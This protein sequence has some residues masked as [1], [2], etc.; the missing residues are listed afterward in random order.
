MIAHAL[1]LRTTPLLCNG[2]RMLFDVP[3]R[4]VEEWRKHVDDDEKWR[5]RELWS[6]FLEM[7]AAR[8]LEIGAEAAALKRH[9]YGRGWSAKNLMN[10]Y[11]A[12][13][14]GGHKVG[15]YKKT[16]PQ[17]APG[18]WR[19]LLRNYTSA[20]KQMLP[21]E[22]VRWLAEQWTEFKG[23][24]DCVEATHRHVIDLWLQGKPIPGYGTV[25][26]WCRRAGR[27]R[28]HP[29]LYRPGE[30][31]GGW[32]EATF[33][34]NLPKRAVVRE[35]IAHGYLAAHHA[36]PDQVL[37]DRSPLLPL[38]YVFLD[39]TRPDLRCLW[40]NP[41]GKGDFVYPLMVLA[42]D[43]C[44]GVDVGTTFKPRGIKH[45]AAEDAGARQERHGVTQDMTLYAIV[46]V[47]RFGVPP[48]G[49]T[50]VHENAAA[51]VPTWAK[52]FLY[53]IYGDRIKFMA[54]G[55]FKEKMTAHGFAD[56]GGAPYDKAPIEAFF[57]IVMTQTARL[58]GSTGP[59]WETIPGEQKQV[60][61]YELKLLEKAGGVESVFKMFDHKSLDW[62]QAVDG[63]TAALHLL[64]FRTGHKLQGFDRVR[65]WRHDASHS[66]R[67][68]NEFLALSQAEQ[69]AVQ[70]IINRVEAPAERFCRL[71]QGVPLLPV[72]ED[73][74]LY[75]QGPRQ[76]VRVRDGKIIVRSQ[77]HSDDELV[78]RETDNALLDEE[79]ERRE[80][81]AVIAEDGSRIV[82]VE[83]GRV[84]G[85]VI[86]Q[87]RVV[88]GTEAWD[89]E[90]GRV[91][92]ARVADRELLRGY[93]LLDTDT[94]LAEM[95][96][97]NEAIAANLPA[98]LPTAKPLQIE[99]KQRRKKQDKRA[100]IE[101][102]I[103]AAE[104]LESEK[105]SKS[106]G[107]LYDTSSDA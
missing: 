30:L 80:F 56:Q 3:D 9:H 22:F 29:K 86:R 92:A 70:D 21:P 81:D 17:Y 27:A 85:H 20:K 69:D 60:E 40:F 6:S 48:W 36:Q 47:L 14:D 72:D 8:N 15:D 103:A 45:A 97:R 63:I 52:E 76:K 12:Y 61:K 13:R 95:R 67:P 91:R 33:R 31:P 5:L 106:E 23:R 82:L 41:Q 59:R 37:T 68:W 57:R 94:A 107:S 10:L 24:K 32:S 26:E 2:E 4:D 93:L 101:S 104:R 74:L 87:G 88:R 35:Q 90:A 64:R 19:I 55:I 83:D 38:Q 77:A 100:E 96:A 89:R 71:L 39:D 66:Y 78:F 54:T 11:R 1:T 58:P 50:F 16:G 73:M 46:Q 79:N 43:A 28:P 53:G 99:E 65:E 98:A 25:D 102:E 75:I 7:L 44:S 105:A 42:L 51:C 34:R 49:I 62:G 84:L 18:D